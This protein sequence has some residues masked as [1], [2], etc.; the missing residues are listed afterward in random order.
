MSSTNKRAKEYN[1][2]LEPTCCICSH[3]DFD[4]EWCDKMERRKH[5]MDSCEDFEL[6]IFREE[7]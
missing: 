5:C 4:S 3:Y 7:E 1:V 6:F 2:V